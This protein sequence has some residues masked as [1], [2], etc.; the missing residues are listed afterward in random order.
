LFPR[1]IRSDFS[2]SSEM[3]DSPLLGVIRVVCG[4]QLNVASYQNG[5]PLIWFDREDR[6]SPCSTDAEILDDRVVGTSHPEG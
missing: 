2:S 1:G 3:I 4:L 5:V 6:A